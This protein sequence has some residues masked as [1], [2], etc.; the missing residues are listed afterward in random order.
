MSTTLSYSTNI[1]VSTS[2]GLFFFSPEEIVRLEA[3]SNYTYLYFVNRKPM[4]ISRVLG[5]FEEL[6][7]QQGFIRTHRSHLV[8]RRYVQYVN[9]EG[10]ITMQD[11]SHAEISRRRKKEVMKTLRD[12]FRFTALAA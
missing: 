10:V 5:E 1:S 7:V 9:A 6:L 11:A 12:N 2:D 4:L 8:N 3:S